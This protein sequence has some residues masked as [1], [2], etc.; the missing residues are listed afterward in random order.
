MEQGLNGLFVYVCLYFCLGQF[1]ICYV[2][3]CEWDVGVV[4]VVVYDVGV[5]IDC[6]ELIVE[7]QFEGCFV[8]LRCVVGVFLVEGVF[9]LFVYGFVFEMIFVVDIVIGG[10]FVN[11]LV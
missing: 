10:Y 5:V 6:I 3:C 8:V 11:G 7:I 9:G 2:C 1:L 4:G